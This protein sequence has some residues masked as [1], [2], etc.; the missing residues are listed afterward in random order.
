MPSH[1]PLT[2]TILKML[3]Y[4]SLANPGLSQGDPS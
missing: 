2:S 3:T 1:C 4:D